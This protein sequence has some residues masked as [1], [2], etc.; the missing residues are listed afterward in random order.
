MALGAFGGGLVLGKLDPF[1]PGAALTAFILVDGHIQTS[2]M[3][4]GF[5]MTIPADPRPVQR[6]RN[7]YLEAHVIDKK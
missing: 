4:R 1:E 5:Q 3:H 2:F 7:P 6:L